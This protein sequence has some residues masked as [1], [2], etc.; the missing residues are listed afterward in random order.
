MTTETTTDLDL[1]VEEAEALDAPFWEY[2]A[3]FAAGL[4]AGAAIG[5]V[6]AT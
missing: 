1:Q 4:A 6:I 5:A 2:V 3:G